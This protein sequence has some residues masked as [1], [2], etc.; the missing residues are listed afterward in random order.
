MEGRRCPGRRIGVAVRRRL[1]VVA[2]GGA[3]LRVG[4]LQLS[5]RRGLA[6]PGCRGSHLRR[7]AD[8][9][10]G[11]PAH[12]RLSPNRSRPANAIPRLSAASRRANASSVRRSS[13]SSSGAALLA[14]AGSASQKR[15]LGVYERGARVAAA[16]AAQ[17]SVVRALVAGADGAAGVSA[18]SRSRQRS[19]RC[20]QPTLSRKSPGGR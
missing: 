15:R 10:A 3:R 2:R 18:W 19:S 9:D 14:A 4:V 20:S 12:T 13:S 1:G 5:C 17:G 11:F 7:C 8:R 16:V 6:D